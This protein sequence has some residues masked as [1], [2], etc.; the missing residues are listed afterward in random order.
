MEL[1]RNITLGEYCLVCALDSGPDDL[2]SR[3]RTVARAIRSGASEAVVRNGSKGLNE[4]SVSQ[5]RPNLS[6]Q[7]HIRI[8]C[9]YM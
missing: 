5:V 3:Y 6:L 7:L 4:I 9:H 2:S 1:P 8:V